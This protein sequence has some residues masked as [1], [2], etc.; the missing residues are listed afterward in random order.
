MNASTTINR[1]SYGYILIGLVAL[2]VA[3]ITQLSSVQ[4]L[5]YGRG[6]YGKCQFGSCSI[7]LTSSTSIA[8]NITPSGS[9]KC[10]VVKDDVS[11]RTGSST[12][13]T[14]QLSDTDTNTN[15]VRTGGGTI[16]ATSG[17]RNVST[18]LSANTWGYRVDGVGSFGAG[19]TSAATN[20]SIPTST[21]AGVPVYGSSDSIA[22]TA[23][24][25]S[26]AVITPVWYGICSN[27]SIPAGTYTDTVLYTALI[28][29]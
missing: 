3:V 9:T 2:V 11:V 18:V 14:L 16:A 20:A 24:A 1:K 22:T 15:L 13:Y 28:N 6:A 7:T 12:G 5:P 23:T 8:A 29:I 25:A 17:T 27:T 4:A 19:P 10:S 26:V 21:Y